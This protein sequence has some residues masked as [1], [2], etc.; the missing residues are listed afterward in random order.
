MFITENSVIRLEDVKR[1]RRRIAVQAGALASGGRILHAGHC[2]Q[3]DRASFDEAS[4]VAERLRC[5][6]RLGNP[7]LQVRVPDGAGQSIA[8]VLVE[9]AALLEYPSSQ[10]RRTDFLAKQ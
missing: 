6:T 5:L 3:N 7:Y 4:H 1:S 9:S 2:G 8:V 10:P